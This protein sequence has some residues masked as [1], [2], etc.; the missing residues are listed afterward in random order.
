M[1]IEE[2]E[3]DPNLNEFEKY[4]LS[5]FIE[6]F[7]EMKKKLSSWEA[8]FTVRTVN[9]LV[10][11]YEDPLL[12]DINKLKPSLVPNPV[13]GY[14]VS[15]CTIIMIIGASLS[16]PRNYCYYEKIAVPIIL[17]YLCIRDTSSPCSACT[18][19]AVCMCCI[20]WLCAQRL[21]WITY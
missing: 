5:K 17:L 20:M 14:S 13:F 10:F 9:D 4:L 18:R 12:K 7:D 16:E 2:L 3:N 15:T 8:V 6:L 1:K 21:S 19:N 11:G